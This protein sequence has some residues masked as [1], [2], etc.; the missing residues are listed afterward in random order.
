LALTEPGLAGQDRPD[1]LGDAREHKQ[2]ATLP[3][4]E[5]MAVAPDEEH[6]VSRRKG[7]DR[8]IVRSRV[9]GGDGIR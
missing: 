5:R 1:A 7:C 4:A 8:E 6:H 9:A 3:P 2:L